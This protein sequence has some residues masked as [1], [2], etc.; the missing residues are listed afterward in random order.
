[1]R[2][3]SPPAIVPL[4]LLFSFTFFLCSSFVLSASR[5]SIYRGASLSVEDHVSDVLT[6]PDQSFACGFYQVGID[7][8]SFS[9]WFAH[10]NIKTVVWTANR[11]QPVNGRSSRVSLHRDGTMVLTDVDGSIVWSTNTT[12][13]NVDKAE[14]LDTGNLVLKNLSGD[15][16]W[17]SFDYPTDTLLPGQ[18]FT[19]RTRLISAMANGTHVSGY[20]TLFFDNDNVLRL[21]YDGPEFS[22]LYWPNP[23]YTNVF[24][25]G[26]TKYNSSR[27]A[28]L[29]VMGRFSSS[30]RTNFFASDM[31]S[32][33]ERRLTLDYD[34]N[35]RL[36]SWDN[37]TASWVVSWLALP[38]QCDIHGLCGRNGVCTYTPIPKCSCPPG[39]ER[40]DPVDWNKGCKPKFTRTC[41][42]TQQFK[43]VELPYTDFWGYD[44][45]YQEQS[46]LEH[47]RE[48]CRAK[49]SCEA[50]VFGLNGV[51]ACY[52]KASL[53]NGRKAPS[54]PGTIYLKLP[55]SLDT[56]E[57]SNLTISDLTC[58]F[59]KVGNQV[60]SSNMY[61]KD[62]KGRTRW[63]YLY[64]FI[65]AIGAIESLFIAS[66]WWCLFRR[67]KVK[68][69][70]EDG[71]RA[72][73]SQFKKFTYAELKKATKNFKEELGR[74]GSGS[75]YKG[76]LEDNRVVAV[77]KLG[78]VIQGEEEFWA[79]VSMIGRVN[80]MNLV[81]MWGFCT[82]K[83]H[84]LL[85]YEYVENGSLDKHL[86]SSSDRSCLLNWKER[87]RIALGTAKGLAYL[88]HECLEWVV[89]CDVKPENILLDSNY[90]PKI[91]DFG[92]A[93]LSQ[94][95]QS[96]SNFSKIR[97][98]K[99]YMAPEWTLN[100]LITAKVD[101]YSY[102]VVLLEI[103]KVIRLSDWVVVDGEHETELTRFLRVVKEK[104]ECGGD[105]WIEDILDPSLR[106]QFNK[107]QAAAMVEVGISCVDE[108]KSKRPTM[109]EV[110]KILLEIE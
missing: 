35:L 54:F 40:S 62:N 26:R 19:R 67:N 53:F 29:D 2:L 87:F 57:P 68:I 1:M 51:G 100:L 79:E 86:F 9:I 21:A 46:S 14:L 16:L 96:G 108:D 4:S 80:H 101:V 31:G 105:S 94:R 76:V 18:P 104:I 10:S 92:L 8:Y 30:D 20:F 66:G 42:Q 60:G 58:G 73:S 93:K 106:G 110:V 44:L 33:I 38:R 24:Q 88:H 13:K 49:C 39:Y 15:I 25:L 47:C 43:F 69:S 37:S 77:K 3:P 85:V 61:G 98:T 55:K 59:S 6:S 102:G 23:D 11:D 63:I 90:E 48:L 64:S 36:Y 50:F 41:N 74:G 22:S 7:A 83:T 52:T 72:I 84:R 91:A 109:D 70:M 81:R 82:E 78:D 107:K 103:V 5:N 28:L 71:Y 32:G 56:S 97:G 95:G 65:Y 75:V 17:Q 34:G 27:T 99:G 89:H 12:N 45:D